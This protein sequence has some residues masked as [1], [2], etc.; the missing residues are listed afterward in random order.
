VSS[1]LLQ[2]MPA[3]SS[4]V[5]AVVAACDGPAALPAQE[6]YEDNFVPKVHRSASSRGLAA[7]A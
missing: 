5:T 3:D 4:L 6:S 2:A 1:S 7:N